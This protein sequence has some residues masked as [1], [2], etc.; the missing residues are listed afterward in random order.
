MFGGEGMRPLSSAGNEWYYQKAMN[1]EILIVDDKIL[2]NVRLHNII[3]AMTAQ[4]QVTPLSFFGVIVP[5][6]RNEC[7]I[8]ANPPR[9]RS[10]WRSAIR[11]ATSTG[12]PPSSVSSSS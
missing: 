4:I 3:T 2:L 6:R 1:E 5:T 9:T 8:T 10:A 11:I 12:R 7:L